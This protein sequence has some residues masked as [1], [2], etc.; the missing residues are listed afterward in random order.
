MTYL[1][2]KQIFE[3]WGLAAKKFNWT[4]R[5]HLKLFEKLLHKMIK[6]KEVVS[7]DAMMILMQCQSSKEQPHHNRISMGRVNKKRD[8]T[9]LKQTRCHVQSTSQALLTHFCVKPTHS[10]GPCAIMILL[11]LQVLL[12]NALLRKMKTNGGRLDAHLTQIDAH[13]RNLRIQCCVTN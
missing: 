3:C 6:K 4:L 1:S 10:K 9:V 2:K 12:I 11:V 8:W 7:S 13:F 5:I